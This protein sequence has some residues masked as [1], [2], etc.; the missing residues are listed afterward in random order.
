MPDLVKDFRLGFWINSGILM[1]WRVRENTSDG[2]VMTGEAVNEENQ[3]II[4]EIKETFHGTQVIDFAYEY[5]CT[6]TRGV[7]LWFS[8]LRMR[9]IHALP[10]SFDCGGFC[11]EDGSDLGEGGI[12][13]LIR[14]S[15]YSP[16]SEAA[17]DQI[18]TVIRKD[19]IT[20][21]NGATIV[22]IDGLTYGDIPCLEQDGIAFYPLKADVIHCRTPEGIPFLFRSEGFCK[23]N[24]VHRIKAW[25]SFDALLMVDSGGGCELVSDEFFNECAHRA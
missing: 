8:S 2:S 4:D 25:I 24:P 3:D 10:I 18:D 14:G 19:M 6:T 12:A 23:T 13:L 21:F 1:W 20:L 5:D 16:D 11:I 7:R 17:I 15:R 9:T 22:D